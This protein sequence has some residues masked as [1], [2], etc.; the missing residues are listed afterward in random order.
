MFGKLK[1]NFISWALF[2]GMI[3]F[4]A[5]ILFFHGGA[6]FFLM[7]AM[8]CIYIGRKRM[9]RTSGTALFWFGLISLIILI[10][11]MATFRFL[12]FVFLL[13][14][15]V[16]FVQSKQN[17]S[18]IKPNIEEI[19]HISFDESIVSRKPLL[20]NVWFGS[21]KTPE[22]AYEWNDV[23]I[24]AGVGDTI[25]DLSYT[26]L[27]KGESVIVIRNFI[28]NIQVLVPYEIEVSVHHSVLAGAVSI[29]Q[30][31]EMRVFNETMHFQTA[32]YKDASQKIKIV[33]SMIA[34]K[35]EVKRI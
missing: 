1:K 7:I 23:N 8:G 17:P 4:L 33:T 30:R 27:P 9:P 35:L 10:F 2:I 24:Q 12:L 16:Q 5:E 22:H 3:L 13:Y 32:G 21:Q 6:I 29:F 18:Y 34:G 28:G 15:I 25:I 20:K 26:V 14:I 19:E 31:S 11:N